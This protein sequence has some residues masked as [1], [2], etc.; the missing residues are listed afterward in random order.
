MLLK[1]TCLLYEASMKFSPEFLPKVMEAISSQL[2]NIDNWT[3][4]A[5][6]TICGKLSR[7]SGKSE[8]AIHKFFRSSKY[9]GVLKMKPTPPPVMAIGA[10]ASPAP[11]A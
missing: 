5:C 3:P 9:A 10:L 2:A 1:W 8:K 4:N 7:E 6:K 11:A